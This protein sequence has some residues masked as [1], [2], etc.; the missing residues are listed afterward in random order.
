MKIYTIKFL[1]IKN[2]LLAIPFL[3]IYF[4]QDDIIN[5]LKGKEND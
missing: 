3:T 4:K 5:S 2:I 1:S